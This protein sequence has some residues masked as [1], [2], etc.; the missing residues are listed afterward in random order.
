MPP[1]NFFLFLTFLSA[2][3]DFF[4]NKHAN[5]QNK[6]LFTQTVA[7]F[8]FYKTKYSKILEERM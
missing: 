6:S 2:L 5:M 8:L 7:S 1:V 3:L 4:L